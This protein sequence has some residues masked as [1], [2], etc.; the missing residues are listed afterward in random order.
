[1]GEPEGGEHLQHRSGTRQGSLAL[2]WFDQLVITATC[3]I[4]TVNQGTT[5][6][7]R[8]AQFEPFRKVS[9]SQ[10]KRSTK[11]LSS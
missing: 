11:A 10:W 9:L 7:Q 2:P 1:M 3:V 6:S 4:I 8:R 5:A